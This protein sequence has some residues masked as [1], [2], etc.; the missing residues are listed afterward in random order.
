MEERGKINES[1]RTNN[2][3]VMFFCFIDL[4][5]ILF[6]YLIF[7]LIQTDCMLVIKIALN[8]LIIDNRSWTAKPRI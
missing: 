2:D 4:L 1:T 8:F 3:Y 5:L 6:C 7:P